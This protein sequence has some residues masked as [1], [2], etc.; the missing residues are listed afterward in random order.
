MAKDEAASVSVNDEASLHGAYPMYAQWVTFDA[1][2]VS[3]VSDTLT[4]R[5]DPR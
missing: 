5:V 2:R 4:M 1:G 3:A